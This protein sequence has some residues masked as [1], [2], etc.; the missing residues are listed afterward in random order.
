[1]STSDVV[2]V[3]EGSGSALKLAVTQA[4]ASLTGLSSDRITVVTGR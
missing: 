4:V 1:M 2:V 3:T